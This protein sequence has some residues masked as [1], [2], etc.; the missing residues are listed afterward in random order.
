MAAWIEGCDARDTEFEIGSTSRNVQR[1]DWEIKSRNQR[2]GEI[3]PYQHQHHHHHHSQHKTPTTKPIPPL[4]R[5]ILHPQPLS[6]LLPFHLPTSQSAR[7]HQ[8]SARNPSRRPEPSPPFSNI[9]PRISLPLFALLHLISLPRS[10]NETSPASTAHN[11]TQIFF[12]FSNLQD[13]NTR[14]QHVLGRTRLENRRDQTMPEFPSDRPIHRSLKHGHYHDHRPRSRPRSRIKNPGPGFASKLTRQRS[15]A[16]P[17]VRR[18]PEPQLQNIQP[19]PR[20]RVEVGSHN[21]SHRERE[22]DGENQRQSRGRRDIG[23]G[24]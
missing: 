14:P 9:H 22:M 10:P 8:L 7:P 1:R 5:L 19:V 11:P 24:G 16:R 12:L 13:L 23:C 15:Q 4:P 17:R 18:I 3:R 21:R 2:N 6:N 20:I